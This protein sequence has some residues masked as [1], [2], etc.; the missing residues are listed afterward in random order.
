MASGP[1]LSNLSL[2]IINELM[3]SMEN[4]SCCWPWSRGSKPI[5]SQKVEERRGRGGGADVAVPEEQEPGP[6]TLA[7]P[8]RPRLSSGGWLGQG[9]NVRGGGAFPLL[10]P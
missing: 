8:E 3:R 4:L 7:W 5:G 9:V 1:G 10:P 2:K 6:Q